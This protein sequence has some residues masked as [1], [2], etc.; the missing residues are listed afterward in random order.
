MKK[1]VTGALALGVILGS[2]SSFASAAELDTVSKI[3]DLTI[4]NKNTTQAISALTTKG[5]S[6]SQFDKVYAAMKK[7][8]GK[9]YKW[10]GSSPNTGFDCSGLMQWGYGTQKIKLPR[11]AQEQYDQTARI[12]RNSLQQGDLVFF[13]GTNGNKSG[14]T[15]VG[16]YI[17]KDKFYNCSSSDGV[18][19]ASLNS[20]YWSKHIAGYGRVK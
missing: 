16:M 9:P 11:T 14:I 10:G 19:E 5:I 20:S 6:A 17:G 12:N 2:G 7:Y 1:I 15:H 4:Q 8:E 13:K 3:E 18:S